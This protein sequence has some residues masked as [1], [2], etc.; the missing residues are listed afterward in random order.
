MD[1]HPAALPCFKVMVDRA[2]RLE[3][4][5]KKTEPANVIRFYKSVILHN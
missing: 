1:P 4:A 3:F 5:Y 2:T